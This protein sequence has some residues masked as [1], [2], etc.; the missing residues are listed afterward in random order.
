MEDELDWHMVKVWFKLSHVT[1]LGRCS[2][3]QRQVGK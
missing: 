2:E 3:T 1:N